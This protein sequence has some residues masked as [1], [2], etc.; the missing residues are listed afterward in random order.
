MHARR[1]AAGTRAGRREEGRNH[2]GEN[3]GN[4]QA[5]HMYQRGTVPHVVP[6]GHLKVGRG[7]SVR[8]YVHFIIVR[9]PYE[10]PGH[11]NRTVRAISGRGRQYEYCTRA[12]RLY[13]YGTLQ[14]TD[15][16]SHRTS[17]V[18]YDEQHHQRIMI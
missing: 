10:Y 13:E 4:R 16:R 3:A 2:A 9:V 1:Q 14:I 7:G 18:L 15:C 5:I 17:T 12:V 8:A 6:R 11:S